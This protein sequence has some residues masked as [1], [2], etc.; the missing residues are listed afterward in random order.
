MVFMCFTKEPHLLCFEQDAAL[1]SDEI[2]FHFYY[3]QLVFDL[4]FISNL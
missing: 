3:I 4:F 2:S 1:I